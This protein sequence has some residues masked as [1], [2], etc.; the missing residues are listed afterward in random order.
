MCD[1]T[2]PPLIKTGSEISCLPGSSSYPPHPEHSPLTAQTFSTMNPL[3][4][5]GSD[6]AQLNRPESSVF[7]PV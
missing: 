5:V 4:A 3:G 1:L 6:G 2:V 7:V